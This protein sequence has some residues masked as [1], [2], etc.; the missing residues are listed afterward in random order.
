M[1][2]IADRYRQHAD[3]FERRIAAAHP[4][5]WAD[6]S[7]CE[8][9]TARDVVDHII[10]MHGAMLRPVGREL[11]PAPSDPLGAFQAARTDVEALLDDPTM[12]TTESPTP[13]GP[14]TAQDHVNQVLID[15][16]ILHGWD[17]AKALRQDPTIDQ[18]EVRRLWSANTAIPAEMM[19]KFRTPGAFGPGIEVLGPEVQVSPDAPLQDRL[20]GFI[21]RDPYWTHR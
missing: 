5:Q 18:A 20:I 13:S 7:P 12:A 14:M 15:D 10:M 9:W 8:K 21:G 4:D 19:A 6:P 2:A 1:N 16:L 3:A 11:S 17:L